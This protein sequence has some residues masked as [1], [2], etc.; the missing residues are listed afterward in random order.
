MSLI[1]GALKINSTL[2][3]GKMGLTQKTPSL[4]HT[5]NTA[6]TKNCLH[7]E[8]PGAEKANF[9]TLDESSYSLYSLIIAYRQFHEKWKS[10]FGSLGSLQRH[11][12]MKRFNVVSDRPNYSKTRI[13]I[14]VSMWQLRFQDDRNTYYLDAQVFVDNGIGHIKVMGY[15]LIQCH[16]PSST[17]CFLVISFE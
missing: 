3:R 15:L 9:I 2:Q 11:C 17:Y 5:G 6:F 16:K 1:F 8:I 12:N 13:G 10:L 14:I 7:K 4:Q